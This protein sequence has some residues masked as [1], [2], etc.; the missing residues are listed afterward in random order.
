MSQERYSAKNKTVH[1]LQGKSSWIVTR[2]APQF[3]ASFDDA[4]SAVVHARE[5]AQ[6]DGALMLVHRADGTVGGREDYQIALPEV[7]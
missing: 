4:E 6:K 2:F 3:N 5:L 7:R 1:V